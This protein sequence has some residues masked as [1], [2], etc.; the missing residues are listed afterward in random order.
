MRLLVVEDDPKIARFLVRGLREEK[1]VVDL[2]SDG[3]SAQERAELEEYDAILLD[4]LLPRR[5]G[6]EVCRGLRAGGRRYPDPHA[7]RPRRGGRPGARARRRRRRL[8]GQA[9]R[10][11]RAPG[12]A[13]GP[14]APRAHPA[15][16]HG[17]ARGRSRGGHPRAPR[18]PGRPSPRADGHGVPPPRVP[19][20][21][22]GHHRQSRPARGAGVGRRVRPLLEP[23]RR[24]RQLPPAQA[25]T[26]PDPHRC[27][28]SATC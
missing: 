25:G 8:R 13:P 22:R 20:P 7:H 26:S 28:E 2:V 6:W 14:R 17:A 10:L 9:L 24:V 4:V 19:G 16:D 23:G 1:H 18:P 21:P 11:R 12:P 5:D 3:V 15:P 27:G